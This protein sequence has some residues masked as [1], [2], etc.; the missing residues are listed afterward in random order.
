MKFDWSMDW[1]ANCQVIVIAVEFIGLTDVNL[2]S[3]RD[4]PVWQYDG[5]KFMINR[6][7]NK[8]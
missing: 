5:R 2:G 1:S 8:K 6:I 7:N 4:G 3:V